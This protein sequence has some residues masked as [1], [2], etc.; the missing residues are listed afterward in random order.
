MTGYDDRDGFIWM[1]GKLVDWRSA[2]VHI[3]THALHYASSVFE[4]ERCYNGKIFK[5]T[6][7]SERLRKSGELLEKEGLSGAFFKGVLNMICWVLFAKSRMAL[8]LT[9]AVTISSPRN[10]RTE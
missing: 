9:K 4:G 7:H 8:A 2:N 5:S 3:L 6:E 10:P 1:D